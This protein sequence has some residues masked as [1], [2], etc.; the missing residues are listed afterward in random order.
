MGLGPLRHIVRL[1]TMRYLLVW[2]RASKKSSTGGSTTGATPTQSPARITTTSGANREAEGSAG[3]TS[4]G[5]CGRTPTV[6]FPRVTTCT[7]STGTPATTLW[8][9]SPVFPRGSTR[10]STFP[11]LGSARQSLTRRSG[12]GSRPGRRNGIARRRAVRGT[13]SRRGGPTRSASRSRSAATAAAQSSERWAAGSRIGS[14]PTRAGLRLGARLGWTTSNGRAP[15]AGR[16]TAPA[17]TLRG[18]SAPKPAL[19]GVA[20]RPDV[21]A[22]AM[23]W[24]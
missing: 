14:A 8:P 15:D 11:H 5:T 13:V 23:V 17:A 10:S 21:D 22:S 16:P 6:R 7:T 19:R 18:S 4:I 9:T 24:V 20:F 2:K 12:R 1:D 3:G